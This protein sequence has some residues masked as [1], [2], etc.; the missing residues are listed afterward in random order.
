MLNIKEIEDYLGITDNE[1]LNYKESVIA[2]YL[3]LYEKY[4]TNENIEYALCDDLGVYIFPIEI[5]EKIGH[6]VAIKE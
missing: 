6:V 4:S 3:A 5:I 2:D 1:D